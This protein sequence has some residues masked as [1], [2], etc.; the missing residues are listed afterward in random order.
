MMRIMVPTPVRYPTPNAS[1]GSPQHT[2]GC[3]PMTAAEVWREANEAVDALR[4]LIEEEVV[5]QHGH[6]L[7]YTSPSPRD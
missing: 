6:C 3:T 2:S 7:L 1:T 5:A 4:G